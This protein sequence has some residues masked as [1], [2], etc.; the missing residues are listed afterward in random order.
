[1]TDAIGKKDLRLNGE[2]VSLATVTR[3]SSPD[4]QPSRTAFLTM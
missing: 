4:D 1:M 3:S 2:R